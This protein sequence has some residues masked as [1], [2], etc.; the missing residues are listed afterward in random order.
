[1]L[2]ARGV[3]YRID[4]MNSC[5]NGGA[6]GSS[7]TFAAALWALDCTHWWAAHHILGVNFHTGESVGRDGKFGPPNYAAFLRQTD[8]QGFAMR[9]QGYA[10][11]AFTQAA[12]G[13]S[14]GV[15][16]QAATA[17][18]FAAYAFRDADGSFYITLINKSPGEPSVPATVTL[19]LPPGTGETNW[20]RL[21]LVLE[22][23]DVAAKTGVRLGGAEVDA[24][25]NWAGQWKNIPAGNAVPLSVIVAAGSATILRCPAAK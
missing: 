1:V 3:P 22:N 23:Q 4:E 14:L 7:D 12:H 11:L 16:V 24:V 13:R 17:L 21:D 19:Q 5:Y 2:A 6:F 8:G 25:G 18:N 10:Y 20:D 15:A 9:P